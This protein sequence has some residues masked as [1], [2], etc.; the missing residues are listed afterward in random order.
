MQTLS[1]QNLVSCETDCSG[2]NGGFPSRAMNWAAFYGIDT[3]SSYPYN[4][5]DGHVDQCSGACYYCSATV[6]RR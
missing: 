5:S 2:C 6:L 1:E 3:E 4:S